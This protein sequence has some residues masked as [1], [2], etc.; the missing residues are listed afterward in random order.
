MKQLF[1]KVKKLFEDSPV[2]D[3][4]DNEMPEESSRIV[5]VAGMDY[6]V[7]VGLTKNRRM[8]IDILLQCRSGFYGD[9]PF[10]YDYQFQLSHSGHRKLGWWQHNAVRR[11]VVDIM[12][13]R[14]LPLVRQQTRL[15][16]NV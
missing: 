10:M 12:H 14:W 2:V 9:Y 1:D 11:W 6:C 13:R 8:N 4:V 3:G 7:E 15:E 16:D 5:S